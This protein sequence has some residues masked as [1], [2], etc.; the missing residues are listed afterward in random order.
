[1]P[2]ENGNN[3]ND[4]QGFHRLGLALAFEHGAP[5]AT[6]AMLRWNANNWQPLIVGK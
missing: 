6:I 4:W 3:V 5:D 1:M 2:D